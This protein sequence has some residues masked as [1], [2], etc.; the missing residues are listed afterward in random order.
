VS[1]RADATDPS[2]NK[3]DILVGFANDQSLEETLP[4]VYLHPDATLLGA[5]FESAMA[6]YLGDVMIQNII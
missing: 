4:F 3:R 5:I 2:R 1:G 6:F